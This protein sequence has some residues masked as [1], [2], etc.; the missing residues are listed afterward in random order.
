GWTRL[1]LV[2]TLPIHRKSAQHLDEV[3]WETTAPVMLED[4]V[5]VPAGTFVQ[6]KVEK[7]TRHGT[8]GDIVM[9][10]VSI[11]FAD[12][13]VAIIGGP[14]TIESEEGTA[15]INPDTGTKAAMVAAPLVG[16]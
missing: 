13:I 8:R 15:W 5:A 4:R 3:Y 14:I 16:R 6:G 10:S 2:L 12:G 7:L 1:A 11:V 9:R